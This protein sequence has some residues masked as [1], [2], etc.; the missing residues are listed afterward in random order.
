MATLIA[1][2][3]IFE[4]KEQEFEK[5]AREMYIETHKEPQCRCYE[6]YRREEQGHYFAVESFD[7]F[8]AFIRA[9]KEPAS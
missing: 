1:H 6:Y 7:D 3:K 2:L 9:P 4:G 8:N 5:V